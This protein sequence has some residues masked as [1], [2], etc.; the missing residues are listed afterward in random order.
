MIIST[1][2]E[3]ELVAFKQLLQRM[4]AVLNKDA[5]LH[6]NYYHARGGQKLEEDVCRALTNCAENT[7]FEGSVRLV[8]G[9]SFPDI[10]AKG[11]FGVEVK[12][13][14]KNHWQSIGSSILESTRDQNV[15]RIFMTFGKLAHPVEFLTKPYEDCL[16]DIVVTHYPRYR[17]DMKLQENHEQTI[18]EKMGMGYDAIRI[19]DNPVSSVADYYRTQLAPGE[20][21][22][23]LPEQE[24]RAVPMKARLWTALS[25]AEKQQYVIEGYS[26]FPEIMGPSSPVKYNRYALW[27]AT[28]KG[29]INTNVRDGFSAGGQVEFNVNGG[30]RV[31]MPAAYGRVRTYRERIRTLI[32]NEDEVVLKTCWN[33]TVWTNRIDQWCR[34]VSEKA[35][36]VEDVGYKKS[37]EVLSTL[38]PEINL[39]KNIY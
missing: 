33:Q 18:F 6:E 37:M 24:D 27:L 30:K 8:S 20:S 7:E 14:A 38:F 1:A 31:M 32:L 29:V 3:K 28:E 13:T 9:S 25:A 39:R 2:Y 21:L 16:S 35:D 26:K 10:V 36:K 19:M 34:L 22:W 5:R 12:S 17:I 11:M 15:K 4:D 23:W